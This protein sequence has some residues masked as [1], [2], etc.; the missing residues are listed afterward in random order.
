LIGYL[1]A[2][3]GRSTP[4]FIVQGSHNTVSACSLPEW[5][6]DDAIDYMNNHFGELLRKE[7]IDFLTRPELQRRRVDSTG[8][9]GTSVHSLEGGPWDTVTPGFLYTGWATKNRN[10]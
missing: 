10:D 7:L 9:R 4:P 1:K 6:P 2:K 5:L 8:S 3:G